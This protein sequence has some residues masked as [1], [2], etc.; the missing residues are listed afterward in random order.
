MDYF[1]EKDFLTVMLL[2]VIYLELHKKIY[3]K[4]TFIYEK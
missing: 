4:Y 3:L 1:V 2:L